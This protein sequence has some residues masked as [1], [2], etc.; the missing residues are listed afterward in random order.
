V[1]DPSLPVAAKKVEPKAVLVG[2]GFVDELLSQVRPLRG[3]DQALEDGVL[4]PLTEVL[5]DFRNVS[6]AASAF[7]AFGVH[8]VGDKNHHGFE[9]PLLTG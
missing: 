1:F 9:F 3:I 7:F 5:T 8:V 2:V 4:D 6:Q